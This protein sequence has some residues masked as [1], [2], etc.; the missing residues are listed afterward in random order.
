MTVPVKVAV[1][2]LAMSCGAAAGQALSVVPVNVLLVPGQKTATLTVT[3]RGDHETAIQIR[4]YAWNQPDGNDQLDETHA[5][6]ISPPITSIPA[7][8]SQ[9]IRLLLKQPPAEKETT[10]RILLDQL[11]PPAETGIVHVVFRLSIPVFSPPARRAAAHLQFH[12]ESET[13]QVYV[14]V[15]NNGL[16]HEVVRDIELSTANGIKLKTDT[17]VSPYILAGATRRWHVT[18]QESLPLPD[19]ILKLTARADGGAIEQQVRVAAKQ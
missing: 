14:V 19:D 7:G 8:A 18:A 1:V 11:P 4:P 15:T 10:Y 16:R 5:L 2:L 13:G 12:V 3:N 17:D 9:L 6:V